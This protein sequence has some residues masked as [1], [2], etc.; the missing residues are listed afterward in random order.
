MLV[1]RYGLPFAPQAVEQACVGEVSRRMVGVF[2]ECRPQKPKGFLN[3]VFFGQAVC[4]VQAS[5]HVPPERIVWPTFA[6]L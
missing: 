1:V 5:F 4:C 6:H 2:A 3:P